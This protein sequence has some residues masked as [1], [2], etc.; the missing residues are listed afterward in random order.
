EESN[1]GPNNLLY[2]NEDNKRLRYDPVTGR[3]ARTR[4][5]DEENVAPVPSLIDANINMLKKK[6]IGIVQQLYVGK[7]QCRICGL[8]FTAKQKSYYTHHLDW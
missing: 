6:Y 3:A 8:R 2:P 5:F 7:F 1:S 4:N